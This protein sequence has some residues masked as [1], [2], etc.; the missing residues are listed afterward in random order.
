V[1]IRQDS[2]ADLL[3]LVTRLA[4]KLECLQLGSGDHDAINTPFMRR[5]QRGVHGCGLYQL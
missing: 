2:A 5:I 1:P 4:M 3:P